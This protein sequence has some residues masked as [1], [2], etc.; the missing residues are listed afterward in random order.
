MQDRGI[1]PSVI[2]NTIKNGSKT[3]QNGGKIQHYD[4]VNNVTVITNKN[5]GVVT[6]HYGQH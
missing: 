4:P 2:E 1:P 5:G 6:T 3:T